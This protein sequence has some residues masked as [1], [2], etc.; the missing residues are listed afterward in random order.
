[1]NNYHQ[2][3]S[4]HKCELC[5]LTFIALP[6]LNHHLKLVHENILKVECNICH[7]TFNQLSNLRTHNKNIHEKKTVEEKTCEKCF[8]PFDSL[9]KL[10]AHHRRVHTTSNGSQH[11]YRDTCFWPS[12]AEIAFSKFDFIE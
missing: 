12:V 5:G 1:M 8:R 2:K 3:N 4:I 11:D 10:D 6:Y 7:Q 9:S